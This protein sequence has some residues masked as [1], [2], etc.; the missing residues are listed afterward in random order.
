MEAAG[1]Q[2]MRRIASGVRRMKVS[3]QFRDD[4]PE[5]QLLYWLSF[6]D[7]RIARIRCISS[8]NPRFIILNNFLNCRSNLRPSLF[9]QILQKRLEDQLE[10]L[11]TQTGPRGPRG[12]S[13]GP[14]PLSAIKKRLERHTCFFTRLASMECSHIATNRLPLAHANLVVS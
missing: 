9:P 12:E 5:A 7:I 8:R 3:Y 13:L 11:R 4:W 10:T 14:H 2:E 6:H 1:A